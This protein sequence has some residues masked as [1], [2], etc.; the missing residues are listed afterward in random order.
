M[1]NVSEKIMLSATLISFLLS[2]SLFFLD[3]KL[4]AIFVGIWVPSILSLTPYVTKMFTPK[5]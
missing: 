4:E 2:V 1:L 3:Y 5:E